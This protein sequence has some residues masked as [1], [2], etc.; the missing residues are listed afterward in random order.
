MRKLRA[1]AIDLSVMIGAI[2]IFLL[3]CE[4]VVFR[5]IWLASDTPRLD[6][7]NEVVR[8]ASNQQGTWRVRDEIAGPYR[9]NGQGWNSGRGDYGVARRLGVSRVAVVGDS[10]VEALQVPYT[11]SL[12][13][14][15]ERTLT[16]KEHPTEVYRFGIAGAPLSQYVHMVEREVVRYRPDL[17][18]VTIVHNDFDESYRTRQGRYTSN[19]MKFRVVD[20]RVTG[21]LPPEP[22]RAG[23]FE[24]VRQSAIVRFLLYRWQVRPQ[25]LVDLILP[26]P[27]GAADGRV[28]ANIEIGGVLSQR[29]EVE[30][31][32]DHAV[33]RLAGLASGIGARLLLV[34]D[35]DRQAIYRNDKSSPVLELNRIMA[36]AAARHGVEFLDLHPIFAAHW[37]AHR[38]RF[39]FYVDGHWNE[40]A[41]S[42]VGTAIAE[43]VG[44]AGRS[45]PGPVKRGE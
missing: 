38:R 7:V 24:A 25:A 31:V 6:F 27:A 20:G 14:I 5:F 2:A 15:L 40:L 26:R 22:W 33:R 30:A 32:A 4:L 41:H 21:E 1:V 45:P 13:E 34:M 35:D 28:A 11:A 43:R 10:Y 17:I 29:R 19:F 9:I 39:E 3:I 23:T 44:H 36:A 12:A 37:A 18:V 42:I 16:G 8:Y